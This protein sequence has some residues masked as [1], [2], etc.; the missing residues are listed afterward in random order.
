MNE[1]QTIFLIY[2]TIL[3]R[4]IYLWPSASRVFL[5]QENSFRIGQMKDDEDEEKQRNGNHLFN[6]IIFSTSDFHSNPYVHL[7]AENADALT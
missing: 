7:K 3:F 6:L 4:L 5:Y 2:S 1:S